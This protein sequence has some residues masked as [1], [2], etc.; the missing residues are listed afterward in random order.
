MSDPE[1]VRLVKPRALPAGAMT[2]TADTAEREALAKRF[3]V[4]AIEALNAHVEFDTKD[5]AVLATG[6]LLATIE[7]PCAITRDPLTY[8]V[9]EPLTLRFVPAGSVA[10]YAPDEEIELD[11]EDLDEIEYE[12]DSFDLGEAIAQ[13]LALAIDPYR[14]GPGADEARKAAGIVSDEDKLPSGPLADAL[15]A[16]KGG[17]E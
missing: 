8:D 13:T 4:T 2:I 16:L 7:Q 10:N 1:L 3:G 6:R 12:G 11:S 14:E 15:A 5:G 17:G 9:D